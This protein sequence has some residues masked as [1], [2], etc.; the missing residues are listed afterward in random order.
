M[1]RARCLVFAVDRACADADPTHVVSTLRVS[2]DMAQQ[3]GWLESDVA[4]GFTHIY[5]HN[6]ARAHQ[7][8]FLAA[9]GE[10]LLPAHRPAPR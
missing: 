6:V 8:R 5:L 1:S 10:L 9:C 3:I 2:S 7:E 4:L